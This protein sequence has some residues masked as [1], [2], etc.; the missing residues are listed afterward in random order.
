MV[1]VHLTETFMAGGFLGSS[2]GEE[3]SMK[4][5]HLHFSA[6]VG[7]RDGKETG[8]LVVHMDEIDAFI[9]SEGGETKSLPMQ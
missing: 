7:N 8:V 4:E 5:A 9:R 2:T 6:V 1:Q 3:R